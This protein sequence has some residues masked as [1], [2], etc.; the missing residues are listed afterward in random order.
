MKKQKF[1]KK[2]EWISADGQDIEIDGEDVMIFK[3]KDGEKHVIRNV[4][5][6]ENVFIMKHGDHDDID[7]ID[8]GKMIQVNVE[9]EDGEKKVTVTTTEDGEEK[10]ETFEG[11]EAD[12]YLDRMKK[13]HD[14][15]I[16]IDGFIREATQRESKKM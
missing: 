9:V 11:K 12:E 10:V 16:D 7:I 6:A 15:I 1:H 3:S 13:E 2:I 8:D 5:G 14:T 4:D